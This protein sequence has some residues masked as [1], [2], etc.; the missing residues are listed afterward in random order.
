MF[1][2]NAGMLNARFVRQKRRIAPS[3]LVGARHSSQVKIQIDKKIFMC[4]R[5]RRAIARTMPLP[6]RSAGIF[7]DAIMPE[8]E[9]RGGGE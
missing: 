2:E 5:R 6:L 8:Q 9:R 3:H 1:C 4:F 7:V